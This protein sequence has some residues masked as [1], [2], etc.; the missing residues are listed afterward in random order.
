VA[1]R[2]PEEGG[3]MKA[4]TLFSGIGA[5]EVAMPGW[6]WLWHAEVEKF[7]CAVM[8]ARHPE[9]VNLGDVNAEDFVERALAA[10]RPDVVVWGAPCQ[11]FSVAGK[12]VGM[13]GAR[14]NLALVGLGIIARIRPRWMVF[15]NVPGLLSSYSGGAE[16][17]RAVRD[18][19]ISRE[20][21]ED[22]DFAAFLSAVRE[23]GYLGCYRV[24]D[25]QHAG[26][27]QRR[28]RVFLVGHLGDWRPAAA[29]LLEPESL[30]GDP[31]PRREAGERAAGTVGASLARC[32]AD[33]GE[34]G[35]IVGAMSSAGG[36]EKKHGQGWGQQDW[37]NGYCVPA[38]PVA[39]TLDAASGKSRGAGTPPELLV[40]GG[41]NTSGSIEA[42]TAVRAKGGTG[43]GE[44]ESETFVVI[45]PSVT[46]DARHAN[47]D[48]DRGALV[49]E[50]ADPIT[51][52]YQKHGGASA[53]KDS[54]PRNLV[55]QTRGSNVGVEDD[56]TG[57]LGSN[58]DRA[59]GSAPMVL[60][61]DT[62]QITH[63]ENRSR[64]DDR[65]PQLSQS[66][67]P[68][69]IAYDSQ[70]VALTG[71]VVGT[72][73]GCD[74]GNR[75]PHALAFSERTRGDDGRGY[76]REPNFIEETSP[77]VETVKPPSVVAFDCKAG[78]DTG[79]AIGD[80]AGALRGEGY[81]GG[82]AAVFKP[83]HY[84]RDGK[85]GGAAADQ[86]PPL[87]ADADKGDQDPVLFTG[88]AVRR[89]TPVE[90]ARLQGFPDYYLDIKFRGKPAAD[91][92]KY[93]ALGNSMCVPEV[94][95]ILTRIESFE[96]LKK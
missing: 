82:H 28:R 61:F 2:L 7:P 60:A 20:C 55:V 58:A 57:T 52:S 14:G 73:S 22:S 80:Q 92:P 64:P 10:G 90:C 89:L 48:Q 95:W 68:P 18:G 84:A 85:S 93:R 34:R 50:I 37:E 69:A 70:N 15:E 8:K 88:A 4:A 21:D 65:S 12:R 79:F 3:A 66:G 46:T 39:G 74:S 91:G 19:A 49:V 87:T 96:G 9:S 44:F 94:R 33:E 47:V 25:A 1:L 13:D 43:H 78:G 75:M 83:S 72:M 54:T 11:D 53:G 23:C 31:P 17:E 26:V 32:S 62:T 63:P 29:V 35:N 24:L 5:P 42:A 51:A 40:Y 36:T 6:T 38:P 30:R 45:A 27:P 86:A 81:G 76:E 67:H 71:D 41:N 59:S 16:A 56:Q 77:T